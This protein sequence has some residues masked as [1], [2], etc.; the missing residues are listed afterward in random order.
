MLQ[1]GV[2]SYCRSWLHIE[3]TGP[4]RNREDE[5]VACRGSI[6]M[7][8]ATLHPSN[9]SSRFEVHSKASSS[10]PKFIV[11]SAHREEIARW[12]QTLKL[13][14]EYYSE[15]GNPAPPA[16][17]T[18]AAR[19]RRP[20]SLKLSPLTDKPPPSSAT[21]LSFTENFLSP[22]LARS[23]SGISLPSR[24]SGNKRR[25]PSPTGTADGMT[26]GGDTISL[27]EATEKD[28]I[29]GNGGPRVG[30]HGIPHDPAYD[31]GVLNMKAQ[32]ELTQQLID[33]ISSSPSSRS[34]N[35][36]G[37]Q[38]EDMVPRQQ[39]VTDALHSSLATLATLI[40]Q[41]HIMSQDRE[42]YLMGRIH[43]EVEARKLWE[44]NMMAIAQQQ[45]DMDRQ[46]SE[47][48]RDNEKKRRALRQ[49]RGYI[50]G[51]G[52]GSVPLS[53]MSPARAEVGSSPT[54][55]GPGI[56][57]VTLGANGP[58]MSTP[59]PASRSADFRRGSVSNAQEVRAAIA[60]AGGGSDS[61]NEDD[62]EF[63]DAIE[64]N[65]LPNLKQHQS[66]A[67]PERSRPV[68]PIQEAKVDE[69]VI[70][71]P[72][73]RVGVKQPE[74]GTIKDLLARNSL[75]PYSHVRSKLPIDDDKRPSVSRESS[76]LAPRRD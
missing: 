7:A 32:V 5:D 26:D 39:A 54:S 65:T 16:M 11:K 61:E 12:I 2:L 9:D 69:Q 46:L 56:L 64:Q 35:R 58:K 30:T 6:A 43:R 1:N 67:Q 53:P 40:S 13:N 3:L 74:R 62:D 4:D 51:L 24:L 19:S 41:Q 42:R 73:T 52:E 49:A 10:V 14:I 50:A 23:L 48:A 36:G 71:E 70:V 75:E 21:T 22:K 45:A 20:A 63:F 47:A 28:S 34:A 57:D 15:G 37:Q 66:I 27:F 29:I 55:T 76:H 59:L 18:E 44:E 25:D 38:L 17:D 31:L 60:A 72:V 8:V 33:S 68:I